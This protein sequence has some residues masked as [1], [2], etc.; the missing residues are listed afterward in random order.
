MG[1]QFEGS[2]K[3]NCQAAFRESNQGGLPE[4]SRKVWKER[5]PKKLFF[6][7]LVRNNGWVGVKRPKLFSENTHSVVC[8]ENI[9]KCPEPY[10]T[11]VGTRKVISRRTFHDDLRPKKIDRNALTEKS[12]LFQDFAQLCPKKFQIGPRAET[13]EDAT[14]EDATEEDATEDDATV[15]DATE[16]DATGEDAREEDAMVWSGLRS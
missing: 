1:P 4:K 3:T 2:M 11:Q 15:E 14:E 7:D 8:T 9:Q 13:E 16:E 12:V 10:N 6:Q 5:G